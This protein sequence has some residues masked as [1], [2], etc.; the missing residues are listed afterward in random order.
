MSKRLEKNT[1]RRRTGAASVAL[2]FLTIALSIS[3]ALPQEF[4]GLSHADINAHKACMDDPR[5]LFH[6]LPYR[7]IIPP[8]TY[9]KLRFNEKEMSVLWA[10]VIGFRAPDIVGQLA[11]E[12]RP[13]LYSYRDKERYPFKA[14][15]IPGLYDRFK[16]GGPPHIG[17]FSTLRIIP[18]RQYYWALPVGE[19][20]KKNA[21]RTKLDDQ[22]YID[23]GSYVAGYPF[24]RPSGTFKAQQIIYNWEKRYLHADSF[25][26]WHTIAGFNEHLEIDFESEVIT[27]YIRLQ[28]RLLMEPFGWFDERARENKEREMEILLPFSPR[29]QYGAAIFQL[30][31]LEPDKLDN[32]LT[33]LPFLRRVRKLSQTDTQDPAMGQDLIYDDA[34]YFRQKLTPRRYPYKYEVIDEREFL[35]FAYSSDGRGYL[36][37]ATKELCDHDFERRPMYVLKLTQL[38]KSYVYSYRIMYI[39]RETFLI[40]YVENYD[41]DGRLYR[42][43]SPRLAFHPEMGMFTFFDGVL[44]DHIDLHSTWGVCYAVPAPVLDRSDV[45]ILSVSG[46]TK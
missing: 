4:Y 7:E 36:S 15:M 24:P 33:Y 30:S 25:Y 35:T 5:P 13:G 11:P 18:T 17:N 41:Q 42:T 21:G 12:I 22:G 10:E 8:K 26:R 6:E 27:K 43:S 19:A 44:A 20:T 31:Y 16:P 14:L 28:G 45:S 34:D 39:D 37:S 3:E 32:W 38:D 2:G 46:L 23:N 29:D 1:N 9:E 40:H